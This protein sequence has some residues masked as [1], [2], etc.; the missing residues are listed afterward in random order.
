MIVD[1]FATDVISSEVVF[2]HLQ[3]TVGV[4][5][6]TSDVR[7]LVTTLVTNL[8]EAGTTIKLVGLAFENLHF[9]Y[10]AL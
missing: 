5:V 4:E 2:T 3:Q 10:V 6:Q 9:E 7:C 1:P 8:Q